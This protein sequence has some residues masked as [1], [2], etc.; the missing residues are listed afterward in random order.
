M[1]ATVKKK[2]PVVIPFSN[3]TEAM[4]WMDNNCDCCARAYHPRSDGEWPSDKTMRQYC[5]DG[6]ECPMKYAID[7]AH[8]TGEM[9]LEVAE[10]VGYA[11]DRMPVKCK[12]WKDR[13]GN[14]NPRGPATPPRKSRG[15]PIPENQMVLGFG[16]SEI[17]Q[18]HTPIKEK[19]TL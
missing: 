16:F 1:M 6:R 4:M 2:E 9:L 19:V 8:I 7:I 15:K 12:E 13:G 18:N 3:G 10:K 14:G 5:R 17:A 11:D